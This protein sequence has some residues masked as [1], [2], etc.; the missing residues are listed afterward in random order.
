NSLR[1]RFYRF[2]DST[3]AVLPPPSPKDVGALSPAAES[4]LA[5]KKLPDTEQIGYLTRVDSANPTADEI[6]AEPI[7]SSETGEVISA[8]VVGFKPFELEARSASVGIN[9]RHRVA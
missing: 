9:R 4:Q 6:T 8:L 5:V 1:A 7:F 3:G 2:L